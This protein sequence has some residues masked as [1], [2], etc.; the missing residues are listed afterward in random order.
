MVKKYVL[1]IL[2]LCGFTD[3]SRAVTYSTVWQ[4][5]D[6]RHVPT[7]G[8]QILFPVSYD[9]YS[10]NTLYFKNLLFS[11]PDDPSKAVIIQLPTPDGSLRDFRVW[12]THIM[13]TELEA[14]YSDIRTFTA[15]L[16]DDPRV[17]AKL[18]YTLKGF[19]A[20]IFD[21]DGTYFIDPY[22][23]V[24]DGY[25]LVYY[26]KDYNRAIGQRMVCEVGDRQRV[27]RQMQHEEK[28]MRLVSGNVLRKYKIAIGCT[29]EYAMAVGGSSPTKAVVLSAI[30]TTL[31]RVNGIYERELAVT[32]QLVNSEDTVIFLTTGAYTNNDIFSLLTQNQDTLDR[33]IGSSNYDLGHVFSTGGGGYAQ[34]GAACDPIWKGQGTSGA[35]SP[36]GD[37]FDVDYVAHE[38]GHEFGAYHTFNDNNEGSC[39][40]NAELSQA[41]EPGSGTTI[42]AY[43]GICDND[44][45]QPHSDAY[46]HASSLMVMQEYIV[47]YANLCAITTSSGNKPAAVPAFSAT[48]TVPYLTPFELTAPQTADSVAD[49]LNTY[50]WE[51]WDLGDFGQTFA[52]TGIHGPIFRSFYP[53]TSR[54]RV[55][56]TLRA[57]LNDTTNYF[58][59]KLPEA[60]RT[61]KFKLSVR[62]ILNGVGCVNFTDDSIQLDVV[63]TGQAF[64]VT[65]PDTNN[66]WKA[67]SSAIVTWNVAGTNIAPINCDSVVISLSVD[68][69]WTYPY[70]LAKVSNIGSAT[71]QVPNLVANKARVKVKGAGNVFFDVSDKNFSIDTIMYTADII[72]YPVPAGHS[73]DNFL[74]LKMNDKD[75][76]S[77]RIYNMLGQMIHAEEGAQQ[78]SINTAGWSSG[79]YFIRIKNNNN[80]RLTIRKFLVE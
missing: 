57:L 52:N 64:K 15:T 12:E 34:I 73:S 3:L 44:N 48:Y 67:N 5:A 26:K 1:I 79:M 40:G 10:L 16:V 33:R 17:T 9:V 6:A 76:Y 39:S 74:Y 13:Q 43:A 47:D 19:H 68:G 30:V 4:K 56:P 20:M 2:L 45:I 31:N 65:S 14:R 60:T 23:N 24:N 21:N 78:F 69:G 36:V 70:M 41:Y 11:L 72:L 59:E 46:F 32:M 66:D 7:E 35:A 42:M 38:I 58:G 25:Y 8:R 22:S 77:V 29:G 55:F 27:V 37:A 63:N 49:T 54:T 18:D 50:C 71:V 51:E 75:N 28:S 53:D 80:N 62:D 61:L